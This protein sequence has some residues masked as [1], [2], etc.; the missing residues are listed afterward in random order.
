MICI[1][2]AKINAALTY[3]LCRPI[4]GWRNG[5]FETEKESRMRLLA[6]LTALVIGGGAAVAGEADVVGV[7]MQK[8]GDGTYSFDVTVRHADTGWKHFANKWEVFAPDGKT[9]LGTRTLYHPHE[10]EQPFTRSQSGVRIPAGTKFVIIRAHE[11][12]HGYGGVEKR[13]ELKP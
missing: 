7:K 2:R 11:S 13:V 5:A 9:V 8:A 4:F 6:V 3:G 1:Y 10:D 12:V